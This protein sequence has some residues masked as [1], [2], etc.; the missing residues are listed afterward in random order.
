MPMKRIIMKNYLFI[1]SFIAYSLLG[2]NK[3]KFDSLP[4]G[5]YTLEHENWAWGYSHSGWI[6]DTDGNVM[7]FDLPSKW[8]RED[9]LG[10]ISE[11]ALL[12]NISY[13]NKKAEKVSKRKLYKHNQLIA[14]AA[15]GK[16]SLH[17]NT[18][19]DMGTRQ[20]TCYWYDET[21]N[22]YKRVILKIE[23]DMEAVNE[24]KNAAKIVDWMKKI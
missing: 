10:Y 15:N 2:C 13:C 3:E 17:D 21:R 12:E 11:S 9:S 14:G 22:L 19:A 23:G 1:I 5:Y 18:T 7:T 4:H 24:S 20:Y 6:I 16:I 8:N